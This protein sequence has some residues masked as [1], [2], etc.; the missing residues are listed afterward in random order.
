MILS[1]YCLDLVYPMLFI[2]YLSYL[3]RWLEAVVI[4]FG[5]YKF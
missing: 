3:D 1:Y 4:P 5:L 2:N